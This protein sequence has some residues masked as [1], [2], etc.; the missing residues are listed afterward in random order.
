MSRKD[1]L[2]L[3]AEEIGF[4]VTEDLKLIYLKKLIEKSEPVERTYDVGVITLISRYDP[5]Q[6]I[7]VEVLIANTITTAPVAIPNAD[8]QKGMQLRVLNLADKCESK[9]KI[10]ILIGGLHY[11]VL[12]AEVVVLVQQFFLVSASD[13]QVLL[14]LETLGIRDETEMSVTDRELLDQFHRDLEFKDGRYEAKLLWRTDPREL[15]NNFNLDKRRFDELKKGFN[16]NE[17]IASAYHETI[18]D[19]ETNGIIEECGRDR[20]EYFVPYRAVVRADKE[21]TKVRVVFNCCSKSGQNLLLND[22]LE[23]GPNLNPSILEVI[24]KFR[25]FKVAFLGDI[26]KAF[27]M[28]GMVPED[29][30]RPDSVSMLNSGLY[31]D[32]LYFGADSMMEEFALSSDAVTILRSDGFKLRKLRSNNSD[33]RDLWVKNGFCESEE[34][35]ELKVLVLNWNP[36]KD[37][38]SLEVK[39]LVDSLRGLDNTKR[40][41]LQTS[42]RIFDPMGL[43]SPFIARIKSLLQEIWEREF[44]RQIMANLPASHVIPGRAF[45]RAGTD[46]CGPFL[47]T[48]RRGKG[49]TCEDVRLRLRLFHHKGGSPGVHR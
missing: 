42:V 11:R 35:V 36:D 29:P 9:A 18:K 13:V 24:M 12:K 41:I 46:F 4:D 10:E 23:A 34:S 37:V 2:R 33:W 47:I 39:G 26:E 1:E 5:D 32:D 25:R 8:V 14:D 28:I 16:K 44:S 20:N 7:S 15:E 31:I 43:I 3:V 48:P 19:Q 27:L 21:T 45:L 40:C 38:L 6:L 30:K 49:E 17:W 22:C